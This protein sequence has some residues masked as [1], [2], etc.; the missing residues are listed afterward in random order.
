LFSPLY[1]DNPQSTKIYKGNSGTNPT[2]RKTSYEA[3]KH[4]EI[5]QNRPIDDN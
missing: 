5:I 1:K 4:K 3:R 2:A